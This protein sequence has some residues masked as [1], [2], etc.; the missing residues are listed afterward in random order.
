MRPDC[1]AAAALLLI[2]SLSA[3]TPSADEAAAVVRE[4]CELDHRGAR[5]S[6]E[7]NPK[8]LALVTWREETAWEEMDVVEW[9]AVGSAKVEG[10]RAIVEVTYQP[11]LEIS[12]PRFTERPGTP[13]SVSFELVPADG[14]WKISAP[15]IRPHVS[16]QSAIAA[17]GQ[18]YDFTAA[19][20]PERAELEATL[21]RLNGKVR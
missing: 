14:S 15:M 2:A 20:T 9:F 13:E 19:G 7:D 6:R 1:R 3:C 16:R 17:M 4:Y 11:I 21:D 12:G 18:L 5:F 10:G 8:T